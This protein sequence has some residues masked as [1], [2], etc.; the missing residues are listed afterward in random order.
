VIGHQIGPGER[1]H[2]DAAAD[3]RKLASVPRWPVTIS[4]FER[5]KPQDN[6]EQTPAYAIGFELYANGISR[7]LSLDYNDFVVNG[8]LTSLEIKDAKPCR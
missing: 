7:N 6:A 8:K 3:E 2:R 4:Y 5:G 1:D